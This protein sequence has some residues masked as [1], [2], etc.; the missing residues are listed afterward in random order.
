MEFLGRVVPCESFSPETAAKAV[1][2]QTCDPMGPFETQNHE[3]NPQELSPADRKLM[4]LIAI[5]LIGKQ[6]QSGGQE[7]SQS[8]GSRSRQ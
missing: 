5:I 3:P 4:F 1:D 2:G 8:K 6:S 7:N